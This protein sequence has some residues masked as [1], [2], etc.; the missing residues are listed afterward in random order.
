MDGAITENLIAL[1]RAPVGSR[2]YDAGAA[3]A[4]PAIIELSDGIEGVGAWPPSIERV[5]ALEPDFI[6]T[7]DRMF[8]QT[9]YAHFA[10]IA[11]TVILRS[12]G[13]WRSDLMDAVLITGDDERAHD[14]INRFYIDAAALDERLPDM[15]VA[16]LRPR[17]QL[18]Q[19]YGTE[20]YATRILGALGLS[21]M[22][23]PEGA[24]N[25]WGDDVA[26]Q[27]SYETLDLIE[28][29]VF[30]VVSY[31]LESEAMDEF[32]SS[33]VWNALPV[34]RRERA[35]VTVATSG[36]S[37]RVTGTDACFH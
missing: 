4:T 22:P 25:R 6:I 28:R 35:S 27:I 37:C 16:L 9:P 3:A 21:L 29:E 31:D 1:D 19:V 17:P 23:V 8:S 24:T 12:T 14:L 20:A 30:F 15:D 32:R 5:S 33:E 2:F 34:V 13:E 11:P 7:P 18:M 10:A 26:G 36:S